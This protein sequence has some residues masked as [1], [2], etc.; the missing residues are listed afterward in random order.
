MN[1]KWLLVC[2]EEF[3]ITASYLWRLQLETY[4][5]DIFQDSII[6]CFY[7]I[8]VQ[9]AGLWIWWKLR[10]LQWKLWLLQ[11]RVK[12][13]LWKW[14]STCSWPIPNS[15][16][17]YTSTSAPNTSTTISP[18]RYLHNCFLAVIVS[19]IT[20][21]GYIILMLQIILPM[22]IMIKFNENNT[23]WTLTST[24]LL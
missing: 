10:L 1:D 14:K 13:L 2:F 15:T 16:S 9:F 22:L 4:G 3:Q 8:I 18:T 6:S 11:S 21:K 12:S 24:Y 7:N 23:N 19:Y 20:K 17:I 5:E